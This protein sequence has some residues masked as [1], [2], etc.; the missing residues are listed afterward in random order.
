MTAKYRHGVRTV[1]KLSETKS[2]TAPA[3]SVLSKRR[4]FI[5]RNIVMKLYNALTR[6]KEEFIPLEDNKVRMYNC[7]P[8]VYNLFHIGNAR[9]FVVFD[10]LRRY[11]KYRGYDVK[12][13]QNFTDIDDKMINQSNSEGIT[14]KEL[15]DR[16]INEYYTDARGLAVMEADEHPK[17]TEN[18]G[19]I[20]KLIKKLEAKGYAY[21]IEGDVYFDTSAYPQY[22]KLSG[23]NLEDLEAGARVSADSR[24]KN[25]A[26]FA[27]WKA[28]KP[29]EPS[30]GSPW[31]KGRPGWHI[32]C[33]AMSMKYLGDTIDIHSGGQD[34]LFPHHENE[35]AQSEAATGKPFARFWLHNGFI[36]VDNEKMSKSLGNFFT[37]RDVVEHYDYEEI[38]FFLLSAQYRSPVNFSDK[39][40]DQSRNGLARIYE[41]LSNLNHIRTTSSEKITDDESSIIDELV[42][43]RDN[44]IIHMDDDMNTADAI[45]DIFELVKQVNLLVSSGGISSPEG[46]GKAASLIKELGGVL[47]L[48]QKDLEVEITDDIRELVE[49]RVEARKNKNF[50]ASDEIR[51]KLREMGILMEDTKE[52]YKLKY[53]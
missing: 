39:L 9:N 40:M 37:V 29:G 1:T 10:T 45:S 25:P 15:A 26:D 43:Y 51:D 17:A 16:N 7:G 21:E 22:G 36:N 11:L 20:I 24:K 35:V 44:F 50:A 28:E 52:G 38:R 46:A 53:L 41:T 48:L 14:V 47:G 49:K 18:I 12:F 31:G 19:E 32:E 42:K 34:L 13:V 27:L 23:H 5:E 8:T 3:A 6:S 30:W 2:G 4:F 33:S